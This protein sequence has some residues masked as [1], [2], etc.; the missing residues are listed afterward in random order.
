MFSAARRRCF[1]GSTSLASFQHCSTHS[2]ATTVTCSGF[3]VQDSGFKI[4]V[5]VFMVQCL[6][7]SSY[8]SALMASV[9]SLQHR[10]TH[11]LLITVTFWG[12]GFRIQG[13]WF[14]VYG[15]ILMVQC[16]WFTVYDS[17]LIIQR[18]WFSVYGSVLVASFVSFQHRATHFLDTTVTCQK[19]IRFEN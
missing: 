17:L 13:L 6:W 11:S 16:L 14:S 1:S 15:S 8:G 7:F 19:L 4:Q 3:R 2:F 9:A 10:S 18:L 12:S 5:S